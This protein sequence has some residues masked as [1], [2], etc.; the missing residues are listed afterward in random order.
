MILNIA[1]IPDLGL[2]VDS[3]Q[4]ESADSIV[5]VPSVITPIVPSAY[6]TAFAFSDPTI[7]GISSYSWSSFQTRT[8]QAATGI[9]INGL[10]KGYWE[11]QWFI[12]LW[13]NYTGAAG[14][15]DEVNIQLRYG[16]APITTIYSMFAQIGQFTNAF[17]TRFLFRDDVAIDLNVPLTGVAESLNIRVCLN[18]QRLI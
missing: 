8:N 3:R 7:D 15:A 9:A 18:A 16:G 5:V 4:M 17:K 2:G 14:A 1:S 10:P 6:P 13:F 12:S 11:L